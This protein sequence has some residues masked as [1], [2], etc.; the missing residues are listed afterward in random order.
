MAAKRSQ[1]QE[2][3]DAHELDDLTSADTL[4]GNKQQPFRQDGRSSTS[5][6]AA[7]PL[8][9]PQELLNAE[10]A[11]TPLT[12]QPEKP[13]A[14]PDISRK[15][16]RLTM[17]SKPPKDLQKGRFKIRVLPT[18]SDNLPPKPSKESKSLRESWLTGQRG[19]RGIERRKPGGSFVRQR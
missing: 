14:K 7:L 19:K 6:R 5:Q 8:L 16:K 13:K 17:D 11:V 15:R 10:P 12:L 3:H 2:L 1:C 18:A 9:L 4:I